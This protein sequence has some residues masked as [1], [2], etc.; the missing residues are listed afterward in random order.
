MSNNVLTLPFEEILELEEGNTLRSIQSNVSEF[1][2][3]TNEWCESKGVD[4][5]TTEYKH[6]VA[7]IMAQIQV[8]LLGKE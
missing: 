5:Y 4:I 3:M 2:G 7:V 8:I 6:Q 1:I